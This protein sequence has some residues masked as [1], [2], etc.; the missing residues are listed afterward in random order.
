LIRGGAAKAIC[1][2]A[3]MIRKDRRCMVS[4]PLRGRLKPALSSI[5]HSSKQKLE[6]MKFLGR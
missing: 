6:S 2:I 5:F 4:V 1:D 3:M